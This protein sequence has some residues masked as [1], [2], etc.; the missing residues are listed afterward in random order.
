MRQGKDVRKVGSPALELESASEV[1][2]AG[3]SNEVDID[4]GL[5][6]VEETDEDPSYTIPEVG[7]LLDSR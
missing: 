6:F 4:E 1:A 7:D 2:L 3:D 5:S